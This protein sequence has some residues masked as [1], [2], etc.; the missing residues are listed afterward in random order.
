MPDR[1]FKIKITGDASNLTQSSQDAGQALEETGKKSEF[2]GLKFGEL[3]KL[4]REL[5]HEFPLAGAAARAM[6]NPIVFAITSAIAA[7]AALK[8]KLDDWNKAMDETGARNAHGS[9]VAGIEAQNEAMATAAASASTFA[10]SLQSVATAYDNIGTASKKALDRLNEF[11]AAQGGINSAAESRDLAKVDLALS[12]GQ[13]SEPQAV[14]Y[15]ANIRERYAKMQ[16]DLKTKE[17]N[18][19]L[20]LERSELDASKKAAPGLMSAEETARQNRDKLQADLAKAK[21]DLPEGE[22]SAEDLRADLFKK[23]EELD[24]AQRIVS[25]GGWDLGGRLPKAQE[26]ASEAQAALDRQNALNAKNRAFIHNAE[27]GLPFAESNANQAQSAVRSNQERINQLSATIPGETQNAAIEQLG[28]TIAGAL[29]GQAGAIGVSSSLHNQE[30]TILG[31]MNA[32]RES[33]KGIPE[34]MIRSLEQLIKLNEESTR[35]LKGYERR[36]ESLEH[37]AANPMH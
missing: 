3:K 22:K 25:S 31:Q 5:G 23:A 4:T 24:K 15:R 21:K 34:S 37:A 28:R 18:E 32:L 14:I 36:I 19:K 20:R 29:R 10:A 30:N 12:T 7:F 26:E 2:L 17:E 8:A 11:T 1:E 16:D 9:F 6:L 35:T 27:T 33:G 13:I